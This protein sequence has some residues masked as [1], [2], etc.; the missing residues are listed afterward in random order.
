M[1]SSRCTS[2][3]RRQTRLSS[4]RTRMRAWSG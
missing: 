2:Q 1:S 4:S 3:P